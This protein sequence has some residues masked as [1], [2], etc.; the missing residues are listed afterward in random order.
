MLNKF[1]MEDCK[2]VGTTMITRCKLS[3]NDESKSIHQTNYRSIIGGLQYLTHTRTD[4]TNAI[5]I[6]VR[7]QADPKE[8]HLAT[9]KRIF[10]YL[11]GTM[12]YGL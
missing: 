12:E 3:K 5:G 6:I 10:R 8:T 11:K 1:G 2:L 7:F 9:M 4:I